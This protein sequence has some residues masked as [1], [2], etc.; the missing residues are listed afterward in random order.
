MFYEVLQ[1]LSKKHIQRDERTEV[2][3][4]VLINLAYM[5]SGMLQL[6]TSS[7]HIAYNYVLYVI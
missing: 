1:G 5:D 6:N 3:G 4:I 7:G 2:I